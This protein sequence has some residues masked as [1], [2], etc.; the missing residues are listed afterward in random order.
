MLT[1]ID[2]IVEV[3][4]ICSEPCNDGTIRSITNQNCPACFECIPCVGPTYSTN[5]SNTQCNTCPNN[6]W[7]NNPLSGS[8]HCVLVKIQHLDFSSGWSIVSMCIATIALI[9]LVAIIV[10]FII[11]WNTLV[12]PGAVTKS[13]KK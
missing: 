6:H 10:I 11:N 2:G 5:S 9:I 13:P 1:N 7:G 12:R 4:S 8:T 3:V